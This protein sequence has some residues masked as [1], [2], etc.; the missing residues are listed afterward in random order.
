[1]KLETISCLLSVSSALAL[2]DRLSAVVPGLLHGNTNG[3][4]P[5]ISRAAKKDALLEQ[6]ESPPYLSIESLGETFILDKSF[7]QNDL[8][9]KKHRNLMLFDDEYEGA[10]AT[11]AILYHGTNHTGICGCD[12]SQQDVDRIVCIVDQP[13]C[14]LAVCIEERDVWHFHVR[15][16]CHA[17]CLQ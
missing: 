12:D 2:E 13:D 4:W 9:G 3:A 7:S 6:E 8:V 16:C 1:M 5:L 15:C 10:C 14:S 11:P 17:V